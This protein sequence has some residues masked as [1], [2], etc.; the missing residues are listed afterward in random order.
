VSDIARQFYFS[1]QHVRTIIKA[2]ND[3][4]FDA[5]VAKYGGGRP[6][7]FSEE[8]KSLIIETALCPPNLLGR[9]FTRW[10]LDK[11]REFVVQQKIVG[12]ISL[13]TLRQMLRGAG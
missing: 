2:F 7:K 8:Q 9:P 10:S 1:P 3:E 13:E 4:G 12:S 6:E 11:L 5:L